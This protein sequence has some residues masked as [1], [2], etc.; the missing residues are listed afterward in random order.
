FAEGL[1]KRVEKDGPADD[2][3][4]VE[5][6]FKLCFSRSPT[7]AERE[8]VLKYLDAQKQANPETA[9]AMTARVLMNLDEFITRE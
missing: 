3:G 7:A 6:A 2:A 4:R 8:R 9:W 1:G 5:Y